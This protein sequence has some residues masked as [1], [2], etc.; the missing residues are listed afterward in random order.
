MTYP[1]TI[2][3]VRPEDTEEQARAR[4]SSKFFSLRSL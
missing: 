1:D 2:S 3:G 4:S